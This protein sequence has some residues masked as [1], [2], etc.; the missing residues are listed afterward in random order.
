MAT[1]KV[2]YG[3]FQSRTGRSGTGCSKASKLIG[4]DL[5]HRQDWL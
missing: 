3:Y 4:S 5:N 1:V 2:V